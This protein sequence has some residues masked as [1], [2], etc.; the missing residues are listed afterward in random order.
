MKKVLKQAII[1][2]SIWIAIWFVFIDQNQHA[3]NY[4]TF[5]AIVFTFI[6]V[7]LIAASTDAIKDHMIEEGKTM[8]SV[9]KPHVSKYSV[10]STVA[11]AIAFALIGNFYLSALWLGVL[12]F[13]SAAH[14]NIY[15]ANQA[16]D[17][18]E[19]QK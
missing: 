13:G 7:L 1:D 8:D 5:I 16:I 9:K 15:E 4:L 6:C 14:K 11:E 12:L 2:G 19:N 18:K 10:V 3:E 17:A